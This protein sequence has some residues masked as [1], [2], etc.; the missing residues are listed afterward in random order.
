[1]VLEICL[2]KR[3]VLKEGSCVGCPHYK[4]LYPCFGCVYAKFVKSERAAKWWFTHVKRH[5]EIVEELDKLP[6]LMY[7]GYA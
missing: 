2:K 5:P 7:A 6:A 4:V 1:M 3:I